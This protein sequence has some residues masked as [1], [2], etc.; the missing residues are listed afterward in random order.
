MNKTLEMLILL[1]NKTDI[2][3]LKKISNL[4]DEYGKLFGVNTPLRIGHFLSQVREEIGP[5]LKPRNENLNYTVPALITLF[6]VF[7]ENILLAHKYGRTKN[8]SAN[9]EMIANIAYANRIGNGSVESGDGWKYRGRFFLQI[10]GKENYTEVQKRIE[11]YIKNTDI[12]ILN[13]DYS[14]NIDVHLIASMAFWIWKDIY[15]AADIGISE[16]ASNKVTSIIN[17]H[18]DSYK[19]RFI[20]FKSISHLI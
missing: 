4:I 16:E 3:Q 20:H 18:T 11:R 1:F 13:N 12:D 5:E 2:N 17:K 9:Q 6:K 10:T 14:N 7:R 8:Q 19:N 15:R